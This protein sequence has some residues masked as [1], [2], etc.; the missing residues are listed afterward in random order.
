MKAKITIALNQAKPV[1]YLSQ[2]FKKCW[3]SIHNSSCNSLINISCNQ[4]QLFS[5]WLMTLIVHKKYIRVFLRWLMMWN[6]NRLR[7]LSIFYLFKEIV[8]SICLI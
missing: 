3:T 8:C 6:K 5:C 1:H 2:N 7:E 4:L